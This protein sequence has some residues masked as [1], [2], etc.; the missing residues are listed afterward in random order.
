MSAFAHR[1]TAA[2]A[3]VAEQRKPRVAAIVTEYRW[4]SHADVICGRL[5]GGNSANGVWHEPKTQLV[6]M[7]AAQVPGTDMSRDMASR[8]GFKIYPTIREALTEGGS[9]LAVDAVVFIGEHGNY[10]S[11]DIGQKLY[12]RYE[13]F[14]QV[15]DVYDAA[16]RGVPTFFD[17][18]LSYSWLKAD[19]MFRR[20]RK[21]GFAFMAGSSIPVT[22]RRPEVDL[23]L[24]TP[25]AEAAAVGYSDLD[26]YG[27]HTLEAL[28]CIVERR[29]GGETGIARAEMLEGAAALEAAKSE[30]VDA[31]LR[32]QNATLD[33]L[34]ATFR[35]TYRDGLRAT[36][37]M[38]KDGAWSVAVRTPKGI[39]ATL[40][41]PKADRP[42]PHFDGMVYL[43]EQMFV[44]GKPPYPA[45]RTLLTTGALS[46]LFESRWAKGP[47]DTPLDV[48]YQAPKESWWQKA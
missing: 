43:M 1:T 17:K 16:G 27:F 7:Y 12:P 39:V 19:E 31:A 21:L 40:L 11:N 26:A 37:P 10:P 24:D 46:Y 4:Y 15:L 38:L 44:T 9:N 28:E 14:S 22:L 32:A 45:E 47:V 18:H 25:V 30:V 6:S 5:L 42:L 20:V 3:G 2:N 23:D 35:L 48:R 29:R 36:V 41:G 34:V 33:G 8:C 13:L